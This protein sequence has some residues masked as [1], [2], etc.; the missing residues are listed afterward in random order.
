MKHIAL[1]LTLLATL[2]ASKCNE[3]TAAAAGG[4]EQLAALVDNKWMLQSLKGNAVSM[5]DGATAP[6]LKML[7]EGERLEGFGGCN[8]LFGGYALDG[9]KVK[10]TNVGSTKKYCEGIQ[11][12]ENAFMSALRDTDGFKM[13]G[14]LLKLLSNG[15]ELAA[16]KAE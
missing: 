9:D 14:A 11:S 15:A 6:W 10:F 5:P 13:D 8:S 7:K 12:T 1:A 16:F 4:A 3:K 2:S